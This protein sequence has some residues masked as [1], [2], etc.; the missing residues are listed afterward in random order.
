LGP[1][2]EFREDGEDDRSF[3]ICTLKIIQVIKCCMCGGEERRIHGF[4]WGNL[5]EGDHR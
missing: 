3:M 4:G 5:K 2:V 1:S